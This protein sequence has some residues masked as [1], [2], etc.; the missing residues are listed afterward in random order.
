MPHKMNEKTIKKQFRVFSGALFATI[1]FIGTVVSF[2]S[3][4]R[5]GYDSISSSAA[6]AAETAKLQLSEIMNS[7]LIMVMKLVNTPIIQ[8][9]FADPSDPQLEE[10][11]Q[12]EFAVYQGEFAGEKQAFWI[13]DI[14]KIF[15]SSYAAPY[16]VDPSLPENYWYNMTL[17]DTDLFN[18]N[19][20]YN[21]DID[22]IALWI[23]APVYSETSFNGRFNPIG[24]LGTG[25]DL[26]NFTEKLYETLP[27]KANIYIFNNTGE[28]TVTRDLAAVAAKRNITDVS[29]IPGNDILRHAVSIDE[30]SDETSVTFT[31]NST[32]YH[33]EYLPTLDWYIAVSYPINEATLL[34]NLLT[35]LFVAM[36]IVVAVVIVLCNIFVGHIGEQLEKRNTELMEANRRAEAANVEKS[37]FLAKMSHEIR[38]PMNA[39]I[40]M[41]ELISRENISDTAREYIVKLRRAAKGLLAIINDI[42][43]FS[44]IESGKLDLVNAP[45]RSSEMLSDVMSIIDIRAEQKS[46][47]FCKDIAPDIPDVLSGDESRVRQILINLLT[48]AVKYTPEGSVTLSINSKAID[49]QK[50]RLSVSVSDT[51][52][53]IEPQN[54]SKL[55][56]T[57]N[58]F[59]SKR[60]AGIEG[61]GLGLAISKNLCNAMGGD[62]VVESVYG[63]GSTFTATMILEKYDIEADLLPAAETESD[64]DVFFTA[65]DAKVLIV[66]DLEINVE[67]AAELLTIAEIEADTALSGREALEK[68]KL[69]KYDL[70]LMDHMMPEMDGIETAAAIRALEGDLYKDVPVIALTAN[71]VS[72]VREMFIQN[73]MND[74]VSKPIEIK[75]LLTALKKWLPAELTTKVQ[76]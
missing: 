51:G 60:N 1:F 64:S 21:P 8:E 69:V 68:C 20:N 70:I 37:N 43:D 62:I 26:T 42:L 15:Y 32:I 17:Y 49:D 72:G 38:T 67:I 61:T 12:N 53:G 76:K 52:I 44:K 73:G 14:D 6:S 54:I 63:E 33:V 22:A 50:I 75:D 56:G 27:D 40:G 36:I 35:W 39:V 57:F 48:N 28:V 24:M 9:Y 16:V 59:D 30:Q 41:G 34:D 65:P 71:A 25:I 13:N 66:D 45:F 19:V 5:M 3:S 58:Q 4:L 47:Q 2:I 29:G 10:A 31:Q 11:A 74:F 7:E 55:F 23:N 18:F 46:L